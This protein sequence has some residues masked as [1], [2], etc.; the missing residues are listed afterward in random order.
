M[1]K[2][3]VSRAIA[4]VLIVLAASAYLSLNPSISLEN[5]K[6]KIAHFAFYGVATFFLYIFIKSYSLVTV[7]TASACLEFLQSFVPNRQ[8]SAVDLLFSL[9]GTL[10]GFFV[11]YLI[12]LKKE[13]NT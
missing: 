9:L 11:A 4:A 1:N 3:A 2:R 10:I 7:A 6:D 13:G 8:A 5:G 12:H